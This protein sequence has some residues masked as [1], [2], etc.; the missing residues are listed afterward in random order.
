MLTIRTLHL[1][2]WATALGAAPGITSLQPE[3]G[4]RGTEITIAG[5]E[6]D[7]VARIQLGI[8][9]ITGGDLLERSPERIR[10]RVPESASS[11]STWVALT[12]ADGSLLD[13]DFDVSFRG[14]G[15][16]IV[17]SV[18]V[19]G[20]QTLVLNVQGFSPGLRVSADGRPAQVEASG[21]NLVVRLPAGAEGRIL[22]VLDGAGNG[23][24]LD[25]PN[26][27]WPPLE[28]KKSSIPPDGK[29]GVPGITGFEPASG[30]G[31]LAIT[32]RGHGLDRVSAARIGS[33][34]LRL[35]R[36]GSDPFL[37]VGDQ[38]SLAFPP[39]VTPVSGAITLAF[40]EGETTSTGTFTAI[41]RRPEVTGFAPARAG[42][43]AWVAFSGTGLDRVAAVAF[44]GAVS[45]E[46][47]GR[48]PARFRVRVP[49]EAR[50][51]PVTLTEPSG[52]GSTVGEF[53]LGEGAPLAYGLEKVYITQGIQDG[54]VP[55]VAGRP[56]MFRAFVLANQANTARPRVRVRLASPSGT[57][58]LEATLPPASTG[59]PT[60]LD[61]DLPGVYQLPVEGALIQPG[62]TLQAELLPDPEQAPGTVPRPSGAVQPLV[63]RDGPV[64]ALRIVPLTYSNRLG[65]TESGSI[66]PDQR[67][68]W[69][70]AVMARFPVREVDFAVLD[71]VAI[72]L[73]ITHGGVEEMVAIRNRLEAIR[74][75]TPG[76]SF[77]HW[78]GVFQ[79]RRPD[80]RG[81]A[82]LVETPGSE[83]GRTSIGIDRS[84]GPTPGME[85][86]CHELAHTLGRRHNGC[87]THADMDP[88]FPEP[89]GGLGGAAFDVAARRP[90]P[91]WARFDMMG[92]VHPQWISAYTYTGL[93]EFLLADRLPAAA[94]PQDCLEVSG[95]LHGSAISLDP[96]LEF[97]ASPEFPAPGEYTLDCLDA[98]G[99]SLLKVP[100][101]P[102]DEAE[103]GPVRSF[104]FLVP[105]D[106]VL[107][108]RLASLRVSSAHTRPVLETRSR[109][110]PARAPAATARGA[111]RV[112]VTW[113]SMAWPLA[114]VREP[115]SGKVLAEAGGGAVQVRTGARRLELL[116]SDGVRTT[117]RRVAVR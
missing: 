70:Q 34:R 11:G 53:T 73:A 100:F 25:H 13:R 67:E 44:G 112:A 89:P 7:K 76:A 23:A 68:A 86:M 24:S 49:A 31:N 83:L 106:P 22:T 57:P 74:L 50:S 113:D 18:P 91:A 46:F 4:A 79:E 109:V 102:R 51:G 96:A 15:P 32:V 47:Q 2:C 101:G 60:E 52:A 8:Q 42:S 64:L 59:L 65:E 56:G 20:L 5:T 114:L 21:D 63:V 36:N 94:P 87:G 16:R 93:L 40:P 95:L 27:P 38:L 75:A 66:A 107:K 58:V 82:F 12:L 62:L 9:E 33:T 108:A 84:D 88:A 14:S 69:R 6:L 39:D 117:E 30:A 29:P 103:G 17:K 43:G 105:M 97:K 61:E 10:F 111:G 48:G 19:D 1:L 78:H 98:Q 45:T 3:R 116:L 41:P 28:E 77:Q 26:Q 81:L 115:G 85:V 92:Y 110:A 55:L 72:D 99:R 37:P 104:N 35:W 54:S 71:P 80:F 90:L